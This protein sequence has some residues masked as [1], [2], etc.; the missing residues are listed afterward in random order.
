MCGMSKVFLFSAVAS[1]GHLLSRV[2]M[3]YFP[4]LNDTNIK[5]TENSTAE[6]Y[7]HSE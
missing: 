2:Q 6:S 1:T 7:T 4:V 5:Y 3:S